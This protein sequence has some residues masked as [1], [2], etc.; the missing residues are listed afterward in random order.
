MSTP[1]PPAPS[2]ERPGDIEIY[3]QKYENFRHFDKLRWQMPGIALA[4]SAGVVALSA[5]P[6]MPL[7]LISLL[8]VLTAMGTAVCA[9]TVHRIRYRLEENREALIEVAR[10][11]GDT[12]VHGPESR[13]AT[14]WLERFMWSVVVCAVIVAALFFAHNHGL[15]SLR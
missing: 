5:R 3:K 8:L 15:I 13:S 12:R 9:Y 14:R 4:I 10:R 6:G 2:V 11:I 7:D 1:V